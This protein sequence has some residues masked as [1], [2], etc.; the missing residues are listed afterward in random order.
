MSLSRI[1]HPWGAA[2]F[3]ALSPPN[4]R[5][6]SFGGLSERSG[7]FEHIEYGVMVRPLSGRM[8]R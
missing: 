5:I 7:E 4:P 6:R 8:L 3:G 1:G 2:E